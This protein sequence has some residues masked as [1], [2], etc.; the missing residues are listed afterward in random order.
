MAAKKPAPAKPAPTTGNLGPITDQPIN[1]AMDP[2]KTAQERLDALTEQHKEM[3]RR[4]DLGLP[5]D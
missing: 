2:A 4:A 5:P 3:Q 1:P